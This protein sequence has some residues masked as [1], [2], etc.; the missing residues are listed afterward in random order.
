MVPNFRL[1]LV[2]FLFVTAFIGTD[3]ARA[4]RRMYPPYNAC[5]NCGECNPCYN[6]YC[7]V[8]NS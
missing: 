6:G 8:R 3:V 4:T 2:T 1:A 5:K 7:K